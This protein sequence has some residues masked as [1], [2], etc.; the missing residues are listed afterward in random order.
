MADTPASDLVTST[1]IA[2]RLGLSHHQNVTNLW[3]RGTDGFPGP[4]FDRNRV[5]LWSWP[6]VREWA[7]RTGRLPGS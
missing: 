5:R 4:A 2:E 3:K 7:V 1:E 6:Q